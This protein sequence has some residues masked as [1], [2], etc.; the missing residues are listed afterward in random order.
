MMNKRSSRLLAWI[1][2]MVMVFNIFPVSSFAE[3]YAQS[4]TFNTSVIVDVTKDA[5]TSYSGS[6]LVIT[7][8]DSDKLPND[9]A[10]GVM[11]YTLPQGVYI[12]AADAAAM[13]NEAVSCSLSQDGSTLVFAWRG[14]K[15]RGFTASL[16]YSTLG[17]F[18]HK[19]ADSNHYVVRYVMDKDT[20]YDGKEM[21][22]A[23]DKVGDWTID[24]FNRQTNNGQNLAVAFNEVKKTSP[25]I[26]GTDNGNNYKWDPDN[27]VFTLYY[28]SNT[29]AVV[30]HYYLIYKDENG[31]ENIQV[32]Q[33]DQNAEAGLSW[34]K[35]TDNSTKDSL[36]VLEFLENVPNIDGDHANWGT[37]YKAIPFHLSNDYIDLNKIVKS[38]KGVDYSLSYYGHTFGEE[39]TIRDGINR[40]HDV[41]WDDETG[42]IRLYYELGR[43]DGASLYTITWKDWDGSDLGTNRIYGGTAPSYNGTPE[44]ADDG[45]KAYVFAG[46]SDGT[47][48]YSADEALPAVTG[49]V[50]YT[51][52]YTE[53]TKHNVTWYNY[54]GT[55]LYTTTAKPDETPAYG[56][57]T[58]TRADEGNVR[59]T[60]SGWGNAVTDA[61]GNVAYTAQYTSET[62][63]QGNGKVN[64]KIKLVYGPNNLYGGDLQIHNLKSNNQTIGYQSLS[65]YGVMEV[66]KEIN[67]GEIYTFDLYTG[68][69][70]QTI[71]AENTTLNNMPATLSQNQQV[72][73]ISFNAPQSGNVSLTFY[74]T[75]PSNGNGGNGGSNGQLTIR[76]D[77]NQENFNKNYY[78][79]ITIAAF[80]AIN[81][82]W[83]NLSTNPEVLSKTVELENGKQYSFTVSNHNSDGENKTHYII[84]TV[85]GTNTTPSYN[86]GT[87]TFTMPAE[88]NATIVITEKAA[89]TAPVE[90]SVNFDMNGGKA[91]DGSVSIAPF[92]GAQG[93]TIVMPANPKKDGYTF[94]NWS[95]SYD[96]VQSTDVT[97][98]A[99]WNENETTIHYLTAD[100]AAGNVSPADANV[101]VVTGTPSNC[102]ATLQNQNYEFSHWSLK[103]G[104]EEVEGYRS[105]NMTLTPAKDDDPNSNGLW[106]ERTYI[107]NWKE[108]VQDYTVTYKYEGTVPAGRTAPASETHKN[109]ETFA[110]ANAPEAVAGYTFGGWKLNGE[111]VSGI[112]TMPR[113]NIEIIG[114]WTINQY[115]LTFDTKGGST[116]A[117]ITQDYG[118]DV[119]APADPTREG[120]TFDG[121]DAEIPAT[122]P[123]ENK[124]ISAKWKINQ[125]TITFDTNGGSAID[126]ITQDYATDVTAPKDPTR[127]GYTFAGWDKEIPATMPAENQTITAKWTINSYTVTY[128]YD[129]DA[130]A[131]A[132]A[133]PAAK[134]YEYGAT[135]PAAAVPSA[136]GYT[137]HGWTGEVSTM[138]ANNVTVHGNWTINQYTLTFDTKG[139]STIA[140]ITQDYATDVTAPAD[141][142]R[143]GYT[144]DGWDAEIPATM[145]AENKTINAK[146]KINQYTI[147]FDTK[148]GSA[149]D[150]I[151]QDYGT[152]VTAPENPTRE[153]Y[154]FTGWDKDIPETMPAEDLTITANW[155]INSYEYTIHHYLKGTT[156]QVM[157]DETK[158]AEFGTTVTAVAAEKYETLDLTVDSYNPSQAITIKT[159]GNVI[160]I[161]YTLPL[162]IEAVN[163]GKVYGAEEPTLTATVT[164]KLPDDEITYK[165]VRDEGNDVGTYNISVTDIAAPGYYT[166]ETAGAE[167]S[168]SKLPVT[169]TIT[170]NTERKDYNGGEQTIEGYE[171]SISDPLYTE[172]DFSFSGTK[173]AQGETVDTYSMGLAADQFTNN[174]DNFDV[175]FSVTDGS[176]EIT[177]KAVTV[178]I[179]GHTE[180]KDYNGGEQTTEGYE[181]SISDPLYT[182][183]D[184]AFSGDKTVKGTI[185]GTYPMGLAAEQ[186]TN[187]NDNFNVTFSVTDGA[188]AIT[189]KAVTVEITGKTDR[190]VYN[191]G[192]Q[193]V[194]GYDVTINDT[195]YTENDFTFNGGKIAKGTNVGTYPMYLAANK[196]TNNNS[197]FDVTFSVVSDGALEITKKAVTAEIT[198]KQERKVYNGSEQT[199]EGYTFSTGDALYTEGD[200]TFSGDKTAAGTNAGTYPMNLA[201]SQFTNN[202]GNFDVTFSVT[203]GSLEITKKPVTVT[204]TGN[205]GSKIYNGSE[206][207]VEGYTVSI[208]DLLY[209]ESNVALTT[210]AAKAAAGT[211]VGTYAMGLAA[212]QFTNTN[213]NFDVTFSIADGSLAI[214][215]APVTVKAADKTK[216]YGADEPEYTWT[217]TGLQGTDTEKDLTVEIARAAGSNVGTYIITPSGAATQGNYNVTFATG[218]LTI[219]PAAVTVTADNKSKNYGGEEPE[220]TAT[221]VGLVN[222][223][224]EN[225]IAYNLTRAEGDDFGTYT[226]TASGKANQGNYTVTFTDGEFSIDR[227]ALT[228]KADDKSKTYDGTIFS[229]LTASV[230]G[231]MNG[232]SENVIEYAFTGND[233]ANAGTYT[234]TP[235]GEAVQG[236]Y[237]VTF[238]SGTLTIGKRAMTLISG[239]GEKEYDGDPLTNSE[240]T[241]ADFADGEGAT[242]QVTGSQTVVGSNPNTFTYALNEG[243]NANNYDITTTPGTLNV[244]N[245]AAKFEIT[246]TANSYDAGEYD[247]TEK[248]AEGLVTTTFEVG[249]H[250]FTV[251]GLSA[252]MTA[253]NA[254]TYTVAVSGTAKV[255]DENNNDVTEQFAVHTAA[256]TLT[257]GQK[258]VTVTADNQNKIYGEGDPELTV[259]IAGVLEGESKDQ[260][261]LDVSRASGDDV[262]TYTITPYGSDDQGNYHVEFATGTLTIGQA[263]AKVSVTGLTKEYGEDDPELEATVT[264]LV[265]GDAE[266]V[267]SYTLAREAGENIGD[268]AITATGE[269]SQGN[270]KVEY[271]PAKLTITPAAV[272]VTADDKSKVY[273]EDDPTLTTTVTGLKNN[274]AETVLTVNVNRAAGTGVGTYAITPS[275]EAAQGNYTVTYVPGTMTITRATATVTADN[276]SK[277]YGEN[278]PTLTATVTGLQNGDDATVITSTQTRTEG[279]AV[280]TYT[281]TPSG[282]TEQGNYNVTYVTG[283]MTITRAPLTVTAVNDSKTYGDA[284]PVLTATVSGLQYTDDENAVTFSVTRERGDGFGTYAITPDGEAEQGN[285]KVTYMPG[286]FSI[287]RANLT[288][289]AD[290]QNKTYDGSIFS[291]DELTA[292]VTGLKYNDTK[293][294]ITYSFSGNENANAGTYTITPSGEAIQG[295]YNVK[296]ETGTLVIG[297]KAMTLL[298]GSAEKEYDGNPL[299]KDEV[300]GAAFADNEGASFDV[301][302]SQT[303]VGSSANTYTTTLNEN[304]NENNYAI[305]E[306]QGVLNVKNRNAKYEITVAGNGGTATYDGTKK[307][308]EGFSTLTFTTEDGNTYTVT[309]LSAHAEGTNAGTYTATIEGEAVV[310]DAQGNDVTKQFAVTL[311]PGTLTIEKAPVTV[312]AKNASKI[313]GEADPGFE[314]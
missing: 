32:F 268:Y 282:K 201:E 85:T 269:N 297:R 223:D 248:T 290:N 130:P 304:T 259:T 105:T 21:K 159:S 141:P 19:T 63:T 247:G 50:T 242:Y 13:S 42:G 40:S 245:R 128:V 48:D 129:N 123:A 230:T 260:I 9:G 93:T 215:A 28:K 6:S 122:M 91:A 117:P 132:A 212:D 301:T 244:V 131:G 296:F 152:A 139:G 167:F 38:E 30:I 57:Q 20:T 254:G 198:G 102:T 195:L 138:P 36:N 300:T 277:V 59:Y 4:G 307:E 188:L 150:P 100:S 145:P 227:A 26:D 25:K 149:I 12:T 253:T 70:I 249:G 271:V 119:T 265:N 303:L 47:T 275:G 11:E 210:K 33:L 34:D 217:A 147:T 287:N 31:V 71:V 161:Y 288:V 196:F 74:E 27:R 194:E 135:V 177:Q 306:N 3:E 286:T 183:D 160:T 165:V 280:G 98:V 158:R 156:I 181:V 284:D 168:I 51:A 305:T 185:V 214:T 225:V 121:W 209:T 66:T 176:L 60:F 285:Y 142:T 313:Y 23:E 261:A 65:K 41:Y 110:V 22:V 293:D 46:W 52:R 189:K 61:D 258:T 155:A 44:R 243:T 108:K 120:Y 29:T 179:T 240:V 172:G 272:T 5:R 89:Q 256:G 262:G 246:V 162:K 203:D 219:T 107:A 211:N 281:I 250:T 62:Q 228:I 126:P 45:N 184:F 83:F 267:L 235:T 298:S 15:A 75:A 146:W 171:V 109:G 78:A 68:L 233:N 8:P 115:T 39:A 17:A 237:N 53:V 232:D 7:V 157:E 103:I 173:V 193:T 14:D 294:I 1:L 49:D 311:E 95:P 222:G 118:T 257:I 190:Q 76:F 202:N 231:L 216:V 73:G 310:L 2:T 153:G 113:N 163:S 92:T 206:Q 238:E 166:V 114:S 178:T 224:S 289:K 82:N 251:S 264:G 67:A 143:E 125:Y 274:E 140:P 35:R 148:G 270:Y 314:A 308:I 291:T 255:T 137:F 169:V 97:M 278:D 136:T 213:D 191:G 229:D 133:V 56:G 187:N 174:N 208:S 252:S 111:A 221:I 112:I 87:V 192:E 273:G 182:E 101:K 226:I 88:G 197:N 69:G 170:G 77:Y 106:T 144:F 90:H 94:Q 207:K 299:T 104:G 16:P 116:I 43:A 295:N 134:A 37:A 55:V 279:Q 175:T 234:I 154:D 312:T 186:F 151:T 236:N 263:T 283:T 127:E 204:I 10:S 86:N 199:A 80:D 96:K 81:P 218:K 276:K 200:F 58:P 124:T 64:L 72:Q 266:R 24:E 164:G 302:G 18:E 292:T 54:D 239:S 180:S 99:Q 220:L 84:D 205:K 79:G 241:G 309:G